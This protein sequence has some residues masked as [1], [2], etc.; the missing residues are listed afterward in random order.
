MH[1]N[2]HSEDLDLERE[3][4][5]CLEG[6]FNQRN[7]DH[8]VVVATMNLRRYAS[9]PRDWQAVHRELSRIFVDPPDVV[10]LQE[11]LEG[12]DILSQAGRSRISPSPRRW[13]LRGQV[14]YK[15]IASSVLR[16]Q[17]LRD[18]VYGSAAELSTCSA[19]SHG[20]LLVNELYIRAA[21]SAWEAIDRNGERQGCGSWPLATRCV[22]WT[23]LR[24]CQRPAGPFVYVLNT[25]LSGGRVEDPHFLALAEERELQMQRLLELFDA[26]LGVA[27][28]DL[29]ILAGSLGAHPKDI[30]PVLVTDA[31][32][33]GFH[34]DELRKRFQD[35]LA[36]PFKVMAEHR[37]KLAYDQF[38]VGSTSPEGR[39]VD[40]MATNYGT[41]VQA[42]ALSSGSHTSLSD[43]DFVKAKFSVPVQQAKGRR[44]PLHSAV[45]E[46]R[47]DSMVQGLKSAQWMKNGALAAAAK[48][49]GF[50]LCTFCFYAFIRK[51]G[52]NQRMRLRCEQ[53]D[54]RRQLETEKHAADELQAELTSEMRELRD[55]CHEQGQTVGL[56]TQ[57]LADARSAIA[58]ELQDAATERAALRG[59]LMSEE[60]QRQKLQ[61]T[62]MHEEAEA[63]SRVEAADQQLAS[64]VAVRDSL[65][66]QLQSALKVQAELR[67]HI[68]AEREGRAE[69]E[70]AGE[71]EL[72]AW[73]RIKETSA[74]SPTHQK[75]SREQ[76]CRLRQHLSAEAAICEQES[77]AFR[78][79]LQ[80]LSEV[81]DLPVTCH[82]AMTSCHGRRFRKAATASSVLWQLW[83]PLG[84]SGRFCKKKL[85][86]KL[87][88]TESRG[89]P[90]ISSSMF[91]Q[92]ILQ[93]RQDNLALELKK[94]RD[95]LNEEVQTEALRQEELFM[96]LDAARRSRSIFQCLFPR[97][98]PPPPPSTPPPPQ[99]TKPPPPRQMPTSALGQSDSRGLERAPTSVAHLQNRRPA[100]V[101]PE[102]SSD[103]GSSSESD[104]EEEKPPPRPPPA[105][106][107]PQGEPDFIESDEV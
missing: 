43:H 13:I 30:G 19:S 39:L 69:L 107:R 34:T 29:G 91:W 52:A 71:R 8:S 61:A 22:V 33:S 95:L 64:M 57:R 15:R 23:K 56:L 65:Q 4:D 83:V 48:A 51:A 63:S 1:Q 89:E 93:C 26:H 2:P 96:E 87:K 76:H 73:E 100:E 47:V 72:V 14:G 59:E 37:W 45:R 41:A 46:H 92:D 90:K 98:Q 106:G 5:E 88:L 32:K 101:Q 74:A 49:I 85:Q 54:L 58:A 67:E 31:S 99:R 81:R 82:V 62:L 3:W 25:Q 27:E 80:E 86:R 84:V 70:V 36:S 40:H 10:C 42:E 9:V 94:E 55:R 11:G 60:S 68:S 78:Q 97:S 38:Q 104:S 53:E 75:S 16:A 6:M 35:Y 66:A 18:A 20:R 102:T 103:E 77:E 44:V 79:T 12:M 28:G 105:R 7:A 24:H 17:A 21:G 50:Q